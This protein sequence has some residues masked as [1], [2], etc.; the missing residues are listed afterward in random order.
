MRSALEQRRAWNIQEQA[1]HE[2]EL[3]A[4]EQRFIG[5][6]SEGTAQW[7]TDE[8]PKQQNNSQKTS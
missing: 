1:K 7:M 2:S 6:A 3:L 5:Y 8:V 4:Q